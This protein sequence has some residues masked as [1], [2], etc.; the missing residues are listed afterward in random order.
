MCGI[1]ALFRDLKVELPPGTLARMTK[2][3]HHRGPDDA[4]MIFLSPTSTGA[5]HLCS[6]DN[7]QWQLALSA[8]RLSIL[9][10]GQAGHMPMGYQGKYWLVYNGE[11]YNFLELRHE[12]EALGHSFRSNADTEVILAAYAEWGTSCFARFRGMWS[13]V[14]FDC[15]RNQ[16]ILCRDRLGIKPLYLW[17]RAGLVAVVSEIK[18]LLSL[19]GFTPVMNSVT[20]AEYL[21]TGYEQPHR[22]F[23]RDVQ[24]VPAGCWLTV[25]FKTLFPSTPQRYWYPERVEATITD[26]ET[27]GSLFAE[28]L[29]ESVALH[30]RSDVPVGCALSGGMDSTALAVLI[31]GLTSQ[32]DVSLN[33]FTVTTPGSLTDERDYVDAVVKHI[34]AMPH[35]VTPD[36]VTFLQEMDQFLYCHDEPVGSLSM[37]AGYC[38]ARLTKKSGITVTLNGQ[39]GDEIL[40]GYWQSY[41]L[42]LRR[43]ARHGHLCSLI[44]HLVGA[45]LRDGNPL[46]LAQIPIMFRRYLLRRK[47]ASLVRLRQTLNVERPSV[48]QQLLALDE[49]AWRLEQIRTVFLPRLL[50]WDDRNSMAFSVEGRY[51]FLDHELIELCLSFTSQT[52]YRCGWT[53]WPLRTGLRHVLPGKIL[54]RRSK[55]AFE[56]PQDAWL[57]GPLRPALEAWLKQDRPLWDYIERADVRHL[58][59]QTWQLR[60][61]RQEPGQ[62]LFR[63]F[64]F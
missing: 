59:Q 18:Q 39:G 13:L 53:K 38:I 17:Q 6:T 61:K 37:Y 5:W 47:P 9:D 33:T 57:C 32:Q 34:H 35:Y 50:K 1:T 45:S 55:L 21:Q 23:L 48:L 3:V 2:A 52:L 7:A 24:V 43:L 30:L 4:G 8:R 36:P 51:P 14:L 40:S 12:L 31:D 22:S 20:A 10:V 25:S 16:A 26:A 15:E 49:A 29:R 41:L 28:K 60:G 27:A 42:Y 58:A 46:L 19:P 62:A 56:V 44:E 54:H 11:V 63:L 64:V